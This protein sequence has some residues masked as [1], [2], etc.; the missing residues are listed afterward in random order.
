MT[1]G[2]LSKWD[3]AK[4]PNGFF[5]LIL[6]H[7]GWYD[8]YLEQVGYP[9]YDT[10]RINTL[11]LELFHNVQKIIVHL[12]LI[13]EFV[14]HLIQIAERIFHLEP[15]KFLLS[16]WRHR[17]Q[18]LWHGLD[19]LH[20]LRLNWL[21]WRLLHS[22]RLADSNGT[23]WSSFVSWHRV[24][25]PRYR[26]DHMYRCIGL[27]TDERKQERKQFCHFRLYNVIFCYSNGSF[28]IQHQYLP[29]YYLF[30]W[31]FWHLVSVDFV[32]RLLKEKT[33]HTFG[34]VAYH[35][36]VMVREYME[37][38]QGNGDHN[39]FWDFLVL[40]LFWVGLDWYW[41][42]NLLVYWTDGAGPPMFAF[43]AVFRTPP[44]WYC[45]FGPTVFM[46]IE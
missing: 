42:N 32:K 29:I 18:I 17:R 37:Q 34:S 25:G 8:T 22:C 19:L 11:R 3:T 41:S 13:A 21:W 12:R 7:L 27:V 14:F 31:Q 39:M 23:G 44:M 38:D 30:Q 40:G 46:T 28:L 26:I 16:A 24:R 10:R 36:S 35:K 33:N 15:L 20:L 43:S 45:M 9:L 2:V 4:R 5:G 6:D 1:Y